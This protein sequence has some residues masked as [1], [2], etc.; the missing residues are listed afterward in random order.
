MR[1]RLGPRQHS[2]DAGDLDVTQ[3]VRKRHGQHPLSE[4]ARDG[5][6]VQCLITTESAHRVQ[7]LVISAQLDPRRAGEIEGLITH[8]RAGCKRRDELPRRALT[9]RL[10]LE[11][12]LDEPLSER[13]RSRSRAASTS[14][15]SSS[16][17][18]AVAACISLIFAFRPGAST[19]ARR[20]SRPN[21]VWRPIRSLSA[22]S[23]ANTA[24]PSPIDGDEWFALGEGSLVFCLVTQRAKTLAHLGIAVVQHYESRFAPSLDQ[25]DE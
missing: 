11:T 7:R 2:A 6:V 20:A 19:R 17:A 8:G 15:K 21:F 5:Q 18:S 13:L 1:H 23:A 9:S 3:V 12:M 24:P 10:E 16:A 4:I 22:S 25:N 14:L